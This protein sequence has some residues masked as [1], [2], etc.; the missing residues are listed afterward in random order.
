MASKIE[1]VHC[2]HGIIN[3][4]CPQMMKGGCLLAKWTCK[5]IN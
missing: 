1:S 4:F 3:D 5:L 2:M